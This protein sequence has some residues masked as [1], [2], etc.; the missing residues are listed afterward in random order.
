MRASA[1]PGIADSRCTVAVLTIF[2][3]RSANRSVD[4]VSS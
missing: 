3:A 1:A 4:S 2:L